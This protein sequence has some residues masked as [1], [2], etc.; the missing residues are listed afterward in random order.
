MPTRTA[1]LTWGRGEGAVPRDPDPPLP[2]PKYWI[3][4]TVSLQRDARTEELGFFFWS[5]PNVPCMHHRRSRIAF[6]GHFSSEQAGFHSSANSDTGHKRQSYR[7]F[8]SGL[9]HV[10][11]SLLHCCGLCLWWEGEMGAGMVRGSFL[12]HFAPVTG[13][14]NPKASGVSRDSV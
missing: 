11:N 6:M 14:E 9:G 1:T 4:R 2:S 7:N 12:Q 13:L 3:R 5:S 8:Y 10:A